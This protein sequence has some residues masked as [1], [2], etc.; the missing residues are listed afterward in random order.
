MNATRNAPKSKHGGSRRWR[1]GVMLAA[2]GMGVFLW[3]AWA[4]SSGG[5]TVG[6]LLVIGA[7][8]LVSLVLTAAGFALMVAGSNPFPDPDFREP[9]EDEPDESAQPAA[10]RPRT[11]AP[12]VSTRRVTINQT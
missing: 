5:G 11:D 7:S 3:L 6:G 2:A 10:Q 4:L 1:H 12:R 9:A 8:A